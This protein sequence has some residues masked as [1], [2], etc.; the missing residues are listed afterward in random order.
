ME[1]NFFFS[2]YWFSQFVFKKLFDEKKRRHSD[3]L[4][5]FANISNN[6]FTSTSTGFFNIQMQ[7]LN[8]N[9]ND[10]HI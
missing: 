3:L 1:I 8:L 6:L 5:E 10:A 7:I 4:F 9:K 2:G